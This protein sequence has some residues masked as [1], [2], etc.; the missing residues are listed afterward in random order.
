MRRIAL[1]L[2]CIVAVGGYI[3]GCGSTGGTASGG[4]TGGFSSGGAAASGGAIGLGG[5][6]ASSGGSGASTSGGSGGSGASSS[7]GSGA[8]GSGGA[9]ASAG[10]SG[11]TGSQ[12]AGVPDVVFSY[13][14]PA[15]DGGF[16]TDASCQDFTAKADPLPLDIYVVLD[17]SGSM[18]NTNPPRW[19]AVTGALKTFFESSSTKGIGAALTLFAHPTKPECNASSYATPMVAMAPLPGSATGQALTLVNTMN[20]YPAGNNPIYTPTLAAITGALTYTKSYKT[21]HPKDSVIVVLA[22]DGIP[23]DPTC[24]STQTASA[25]QTAIANGYN[26]SPSIRTFV[27]GIDP[28]S[29]MQ[30]NLSNWAKAGGGQSFDVATSGGSSQFLQAM[31]SIQK[32]A[33]GCKYSMPTTDAGI[34]DPSKVKVQYTPGGSSTPQDLTKV[35]GSGACGS[36]GGW[37]Y[38][39]N[40]NPSTITLCKASCDT[41]QADSG[42]KVAVY[43][44]CLGS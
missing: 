31:Q 43:L 33:L 13:D 41:V 30:T 44:G 15:D 29:T 18:A 12:D 2:A 1:G 39:N 42:A 25:V 34:I 26:G 23:G 16:N 38:D 9:D 22:T 7:G 20:Q 36:G 5:G 32:S 11:A 10:G 37:Y 21:A 4:S 8:T 27:I 14:G 3:A 40:Q 24:G 35:S 17:R 6:G 28:T 19:P